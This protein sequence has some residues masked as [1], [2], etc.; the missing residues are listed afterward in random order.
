MVD[1]P[2]TVRGSGLDRSQSGGQWWNYR[3]PSVPAKQ[4]APGP[5]VSREAISPPPDNESSADRSPPRRSAPPSS[6]SGATLIAGTLLVVVLAAAHFAQAPILARV[7]VPAV[8]LFGTIAFAQRLAPRH[9]DEPWLARFLVLG[10]IVKLVASVL[11]Y[12][13]LVNSFGSVGDATVFDTYGRRYST[14][15][16][17]HGGA[18]PHLDNLRKSNFLRWFT[19]V[20]YYLFGTDMITGFFVFGLLA[21]LGSY[22]WYR[23]TV[24]AVPFLD[25]R[26]YLMV[27]MFVP[28][29]VF[30]PSSIGKEA[31]MQFAI[32]SAALGT[33]HLLN[34]RFLRGLLVAIPGAWLLWVVRPHLLAIV[35]LGAAA[36]YILG[37]A[38]RRA[39]SERGSIFKPIG[40]ILVAFLAV[41]AVN[42]GAKGL[43]IQSLSLGSVQA[44]L[45]KTSASTGQGGSAFSNGGNSLSPL[46]LPQDFVTVLLRPFPW[47]VQSALQILASLEGMALAVFIVVRRSSVALSL[48]RLRSSPFLAYCWTLTFL[49]ALTFQ[50]FSNFGLLVRER[51]LVLPAMYVLLCLDPARADAGRESDLRRVATAVG[52]RRDRVG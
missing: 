34:G 18:L 10:M 39:A 25:R 49:Y 30:W 6:A 50:S 7:L 15:W 52:S 31:L 28:S 22:L 38:P 44:E 4:A 47:E 32:G 14:V 46:R 1:R 26:L 11:R 40:M 51:S 23:A 20:V 48:R 27:V 21:F 12:R 8:G 9:P 41:F 19:G 35:T 43:G 36:A 2:R 45:D 24:E 16:L 5:V 33:A 3:R 42:Q 13:T 17:G 37:R 29:I